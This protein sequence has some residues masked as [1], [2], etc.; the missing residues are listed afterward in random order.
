MAMTLLPLSGV[1]IGLANCASPYGGA[2][3]GGPQIVE[4]SKALI[5]PAPGGPSVISVIEE[6]F[7]NAIEQ[8][9][10][11]STTAS[12]SGQN[13]FSIRM[14]GPM[15]TDMQGA[16]PLDYTAVSAGQQVQDARRAV[17]GVA[18]KPSALF[19]RNSYGPFSYAFGQ[20]SGG[21]SCLYGWQQVSAQDGGQASFASV[22]AI[23]V[24]LRLCEAGAS[25]KDLLAVMYSYTITGSFPSEH[26]N[27]YGAPQ[28]VANV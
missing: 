25:E 23:Q 19:L 24:R 2:Q 26:W 28:D 7:S 15:E 10:M 9:V 11:V 21:D 4:A 27:P 1:G 12:A 20:S 5:M 14:Y 16:K 17:P 18:M 22:G 3:M 13:Y 6:R 8:K